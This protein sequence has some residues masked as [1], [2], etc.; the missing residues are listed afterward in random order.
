MIL[1]V[2]VVVY[3]FNGFHQHYRLD[4]TEIA[5]LPGYFLELLFTPQFLLNNGLRTDVNPIGKWL[6]F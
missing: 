2:V 3:K 1:P 5:K 6:I 4:S